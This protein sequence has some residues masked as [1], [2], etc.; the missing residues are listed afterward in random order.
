MTA[1]IRE[2][3]PRIV[4]PSD[5]YYE[6]GSL[7]AFEDF[8]QKKMKLGKDASI[9]HGNRYIQLHFNSEGPV[10]S[11]AFKELSRSLAGLAQLILRSD[12]MPSYV[13]G[14]TNAHMAKASE[15]YGFSTVRFPTNDEEFQ[16]SLVSSTVF[17]AR[18][19]K[20][21]Q[22]ENIES[23]ITYQSAEQF[24]KRFD[25]AKTGVKPADVLYSTPITRLVRAHLRLEV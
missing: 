8:A 10:G 19:K 15:R 24:V 3:D 4:F 23:W 14:V 12:P 18:Y 11:K 2:R 6:I 25:P 13:Y 16:R 22:T 7:V 5:N 9:K 20:R 17:S 21:K 1:V